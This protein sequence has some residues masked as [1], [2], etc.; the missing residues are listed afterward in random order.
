MNPMTAVD[1]ARLT[2]PHGIPID[3]ST[4]SLNSSGLKSGN[5]TASYDGNS[6]SNNTPCLMIVLDVRVKSLKSVAAHVCVY[7]YVYAYAYACVY[8]CVYTYMY[9]CIYVCVHKNIYYIYIYMY[10]YTGTKLQPPWPPDKAAGGLSSLL[11]GAFKR[12]FEGRPWIP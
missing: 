4:T 7:V 1:V 8:V 10:T 3:A 9:M 11:L 5:Y 12:S 2:N 6:L